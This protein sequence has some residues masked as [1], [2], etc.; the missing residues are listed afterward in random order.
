[1]ESTVRGAIEVNARRDYFVNGRRPAVASWVGTYSHAGMRSV[2]W[3][4]SSSMRSRSN[5]SVVRPLGIWPAV[6][7]GDRAA[8]LRQER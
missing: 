8:R 1:M 4:N 3:L 6:R 7:Y 2:K 5:I